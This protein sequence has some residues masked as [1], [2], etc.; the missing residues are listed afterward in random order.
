MGE[1]SR[2]RETTTEVKN[3]VE[4]KFKEIKP[5]SDI[6]IEDARNFFDKLFNKFENTENGEGDNPE[7]D[8]EKVIQDYSKDLKDKSECPE[9][10]PDKLFDASDLKKRTPEENAE[11]REEFADRRTQLKK[12][13]EK[14]NGGRPWPKYDHDVFSKNGNRIRGAGDDYDAHHIL[15][16]HL[17]GENVASNITPLNV[18]VHYDKQGIHAQD[19]S[20]SKLDQISGGMD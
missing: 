1:I 17:G 6:T 16:L 14:A 9:T 20:C 7:N 2:G 18:D 15:P 3:P 19:S 13:W 4:E 12:E 10:I 11:K 5:E 8:I